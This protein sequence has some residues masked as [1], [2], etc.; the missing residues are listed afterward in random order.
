[1][2]RK[3]NAVYVISAAA[4]LSGMHPQTLRIYERK[5]LVQPARTTGGSR[6]YSDEDVALLLRISE[7][8]SEGMNL[9]GVKKILELEQRVTELEAK[10]E[11]QLRAS[12]IRREQ[13]RV[14]ERSYAHDLVPVRQTVAIY[15]PS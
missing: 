3:A 6:R 13:R 7:L 12:R 2:A 1:M 9:V 8:T 4:E 15:K 11:H 5:G 14:S 10:L